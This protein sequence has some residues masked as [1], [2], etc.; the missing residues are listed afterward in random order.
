MV[1]LI[2]GAISASFIFF[3]AF[4]NSQTVTVRFLNYLSGEISLYLVVIISMVAGII[5]SLV[6][7]IPGY[8]SATV[9]MFNKDRKIKSTEKTLEKVENKVK[10]LEIEN[11]TLKN[12]SRGPSFM[13]QSVLDKPNFFQKI[14]DRL[15]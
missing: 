8:I 4:Q 2:I 13:K 10:G 5:L 3:F 6:I 12:N 14:R 7:S 11:T 9:N 1:S 15:T